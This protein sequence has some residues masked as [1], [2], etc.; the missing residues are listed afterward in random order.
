MNIMNR[1]DAEL[2]GCDILYDGFFRMKRYRFRHRLYDGGWSAPVSREVF[3]REA[4]VSVIPYD[5]IRQRVVLI[6]Q[7]RPGPMAAGDEN[8]WV[9]EIIAGIVEPDENL[10]DVA[11][12]EAIEEAGCQI[13]QLIPISTHYVSPG[14]STELM[15]IFCG[16]TDSEGVGGTYGLSE[17]GEDIRAFSEPLSDALARISAGTIRNSFTIIAL[18]WLA[19]NREHLAA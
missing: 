11:K 13:D 1:Y 2:L 9:T 10:E 17:E 18:Q 4:C 7:F 16:L 19:L 5:P 8:P 14:G 15:H 12:R 6:E 3:E